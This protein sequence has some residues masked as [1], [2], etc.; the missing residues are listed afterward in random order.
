MRVPQAEA[1]THILCDILGTS[2]LTDAESELPKLH[3][4]LTED[5]VT[6]L[7]NSNLE[8]SYCCIC[9]RGVAVVGWAVGYMQKC[10]LATALYGLCI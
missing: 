9:K 10:D 3:P 7:G 6:V 8:G 2:S 5:C 4:D 1:V